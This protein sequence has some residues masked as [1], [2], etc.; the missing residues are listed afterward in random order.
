[1][2]AALH[3]ARAA[4]NPNRFSFRVNT[5]FARLAAVRAG[6]GVG[7]IPKFVSHQYPDLVPVDLGV[8]P[9]IRELWLVAHPD[10]RAV[11]RIRVTFD[12]IV[13]AVAGARDILM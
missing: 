7:I 5:L 3:T 13:N 12:Y 10:V 4:G 11:A 6:V 9:L 2:P 8:E 1:M